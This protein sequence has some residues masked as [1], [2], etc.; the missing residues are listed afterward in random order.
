MLSIIICNYNPDR[1]PILEQNIKQFIGLQN[2]EIVIIDNQ[3]NNYSI[4]QAYNLGVQKSIYNYILFIHDDI[5]F[6]TKEFGIILLSLS[7]PNLGVLGVAGAKIKTSITSPWW[8]SNHETVKEG[9]VYQYNFQH[10]KNSAPQKINVG[11]ENE[12]QV[13]EVI[14]VD[15]VF[16]FTTKEN[17]IKNPF[18]ER[19]NSFHFYDLDFSLSLKK[20]GKTNYVSNA[21]LL[22]HFSAG[23]LNKD[24]IKSSFFFEKKWKDFKTFNLNKNRDN[25]Y[26][27]K[28]AFNSR[29]R[30]L[31]ENKC[32]MEGM[33]LFLL[34]LKF[35]SIGNIKY[36]IRSL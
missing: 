17:C 35:W 28:L 3:N 24:W 4:F 12:N 23:S 1:I 34:N 7:L 29:L 5:N 22:E 10:F 25:K 8:I 11:F 21:I 13:E 2:F 6:Q 30:V 15:G 27:E 26:F 31:L 33:K 9:A 16:L 19:Y 32:F 18:D 14:L 20:N 36:L